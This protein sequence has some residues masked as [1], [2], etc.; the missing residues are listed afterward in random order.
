MDIFL[1][2]LKYTRYLAHLVKANGL[3]NFT[4]EQYKVT[5][6]I[7]ALEYRIDGMIKAKKKVLDSK[8]SGQLDF[9]VFQ[10]G[11]RLIEITGNVPEKDFWQ[12]LFGKDIS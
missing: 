4:L 7:L 10:E 8:F 12:G 5:I 2:V 11:K 6:N 9:M 1:F 3:P